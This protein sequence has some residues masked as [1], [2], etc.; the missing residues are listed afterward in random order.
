MRHQ[1]ISVTL[2]ARLHLGFLD[3]EGGLGRRFGSLGMALDGPATRLRLGAG[4]PARGLAAQGLTTNGLTVR[5]P[6]AARGRFYL[7]QT[8]EHFGLGGDLHLE[9]EEA[10][11]AHAGLGSGTQLALGVGIAVCRYHG[12]DVGPKDVAR[13]LDR[14]ARSGIG[15]GA[16]ERGG[17]LLDGGRGAGDEPPPIISRLPFPEA[18]RVLLVFDRRRAGVHGGA[19]AEAF[20]DLAPF[21]ADSAAHLCRLTLMA[22]LPALAEGDLDR[23]GGAITEMQQ[24][25]GDYFAP[26]QG[27]RFASAAVAEVLDWLQAEEIRGVGQSSWGPTGFALIGSQGE[28]GRL[29]TAARELWPTETGLDFDLRRGR[30]EGVRVEVGELIPA[31]V[32]KS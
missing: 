29:L 28:A 21:P 26:S 18:W 32:A 15:L 10:I 12:L 5:G 24:V 22:A 7:V 20:R 3:L 13:L 17:V 4:P 8:V 31:A 16:F 14:G 9:I 1:S 19:E 23:F 11:P 27:G 2:P 30:N 6:D 25:I